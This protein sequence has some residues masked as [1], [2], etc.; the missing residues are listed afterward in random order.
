M[1]PCLQLEGRA[2][3]SEEEFA[4]ATLTL[5][6]LSMEMGRAAAYPAPRCNLSWMVMGEHAAGGNNRLPLAVNHVRPA[7][8]AREPSGSA[9]GTSQ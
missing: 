9:V 6:R 7:G 5:L 3:A 8:A 1:R 2:W 4:A